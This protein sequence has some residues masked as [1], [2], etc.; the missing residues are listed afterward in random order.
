LA[1]QAVVAAVEMVVLHQEQLVQR[2]F[3][4]N[5]VVPLVQA[6]L[7]APLVD[8][9]T[10]QAAA[11]LHLVQIIVALEEMDFLVAAVRVLGVQAI[12]LLVLVVQ[13]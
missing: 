10:V 3:L 5:P 4:D 13:V 1:V 8:L 12:L 2:D 7:L 9:L 11:V 6:V